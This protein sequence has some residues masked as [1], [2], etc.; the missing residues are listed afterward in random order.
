MSFSNE[1]ASGG[2]VAACNGIGTMNASYGNLRHPAGTAPS[3]YRILVDVLPPAAGA[4]ATQPRLRLPL[5]ILG[6]AH[7]DA[8]YGIAFPDEGSLVDQ[9][10]SGQY[11]PPCMS[12]SGF[13]PAMDFTTIAWGVFSNWFE[14]PV[15]DPVIYETPRC[16]GDV[17]LT[18][19]SSAVG[20]EHDEAGST[21][22]SARTRSSWWFDVETPSVSP[23]SPG[24]AG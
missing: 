16:Q 9:T 17:C 23:G 14:T 13:T 6:G 19:V 22:V 15:H 18:R 2:Y 8:G 4:P 7:S 12:T 24:R 1:I 10:W 21:S 20:W 5:M 11:P 3:Q